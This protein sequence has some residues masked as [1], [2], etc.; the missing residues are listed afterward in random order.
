MQY[1]IFT[2]NR[3]Y[4]MDIKNHISFTNLP[5]NLLKMIFD[6]NIYKYINF[7]I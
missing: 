4:C 3:Y 1:L 7:D 6:I 2:T 5:Y